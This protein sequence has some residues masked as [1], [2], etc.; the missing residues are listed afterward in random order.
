MKH[1]TQRRPGGPAINIYPI[2]HYYPNGR[3]LVEYEC[4]ACGKIHK[5]WIHCNDITDFRHNNYCEN[6]QPII[7]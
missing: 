3:V 4:P 2:F 7:I 6:C 5:D 1:T